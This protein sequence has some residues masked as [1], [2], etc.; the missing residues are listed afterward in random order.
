MD[1]CILS[2]GNELTLGQTVDTNTAWLSRRLAELGIRVRLHVTVSDECEAIRRELERACEWADVVLATGGLGP[3]ADDLTRDALAALMGVGLVRH[4]ASVEQIRA[5]FADRGR[6]MPEANIVQAM[7]PA[8]CEPMVNTCGTAPGIRGQWKRARIF[9][10]PGVPREM[11]MMYD[12]D[13]LPALAP[14][15]GEGVILATTLYCHG[16]GES[17]IGERIRDLMARDRNPTVGTTAKQ[18]IIGVRIHA[19][20]R[21]RE[22]AERLLDGDRAEV[23]RR[24]G[25]LVFGENDDRLATPV[26]ALLL[27]RGLT[28]STAESCTGGLLAG[29]LTDIPGSSGYFLQGVVTYSNAAKTDR[30][31]VP[32]E[33]IARHGAVS[34]EVAEAMALGCRRMSGSDLAVSVTGI[35][36]PGGGTPD[37]PVGLVYIGLADAEGCVVSE[38]RM[39]SDLAREEIR[40]RTCKA[41]LNR[42]RLKL[43]ESA[44]S[45]AA[46]S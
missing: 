30:L 39:G 37:K 40:D 6:T 38:H 29:R 45:R 23:R 24:L 25:T 33:L 20:G 26:A 15:A 28:V 19:Q 9:V 14:L 22:E 8:G 42:L 21:T 36:G 17:D 43:L 13:V 46:T 11:Q 18:T 41:A 16:A 7:I 12:R 34:R 35:A 31:G 4:E 2:I 27:E 5:F 3:T 32:P 1:A 44:T 10:M